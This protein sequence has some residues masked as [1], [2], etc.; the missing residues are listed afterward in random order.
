MRIVFPD[1]FKGE[2]R[3]HLTENQYQRVYESLLHLPKDFEYLNQDTITEYYDGYVKFFLY[4]D[5][6]E[7]IPDH[8]Q[9]MNKVG[10]AY[11]YLTDCAYIK[12]TKN[13][14]EF[15]LTATVHVNENQIYNDGVYEYEEVGIPFLA[16]LGRQIYWYE[17]SEE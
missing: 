10:Y 13:D 15:F 7:D 6:K 1:Y 9:I 8:I 16:E 17:L 11:G 5:S 12:D 3:Y 2:E 14:I 4:G